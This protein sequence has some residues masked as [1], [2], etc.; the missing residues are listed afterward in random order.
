MYAADHD[1]HLP[2]ANNWMDATFAYTKN[3]TLY[4]DPELKDR[5][6]GEYGF[7]YYLPVSGIDVGEVSNHAEV[8][9]A[10]QS[11]FLHWN[12]YGF[13]SSVRMTNGGANV[14]FLDGHAKQMKE[15]WFQTPVQI[16]FR[17]PSETK[18]TM[19]D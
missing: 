14:A 19:R 8:P 10:F 1:N 11:I 13:L 3:G 2:L 18:R 4:M 9:L 5:K 15:E 7:A 12:A 17:P 16:K 6:E